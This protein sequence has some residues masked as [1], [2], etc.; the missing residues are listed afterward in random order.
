MIHHET[1]NY[2][3]SIHTVTSIP[4]GPAVQID[5]KLSSAA[6]SIKSISSDAVQSIR[7]RSSMRSHIEF[8]GQDGHRR[9]STRA[10]DMLATHIAESSDDRWFERSIKGQVNGILHFSKLLS[11][12]QIRAA[13]IVD[14]FFSEKALKQ[15][16]M[17]VES[18][19]VEIT[20]V[21][22]WVNIDPDTG[23]IWSTALILLRRHWNMSVHFSIPG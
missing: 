11:S 18:R 12:G 9:F 5:D 23:H 22:S 20:I 7:G 17:R 2:L 13:T 6:K 3:L 19:D 8:A 16:L 4:S 21:T 1:A 10:R 15:V 14:P